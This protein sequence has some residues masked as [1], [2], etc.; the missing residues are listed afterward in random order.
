MSIVVAEPIMQIML[1]STETIYS[2]PQHHTYVHISNTNNLCSLLY[3][4]ALLCPPIQEAQICLP[5]NG[6]HSREHE[7]VL[8]HDKSKADRRHRRP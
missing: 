4:F 1:D 6:E 7:S 8:R 5:T 2:L 3:C